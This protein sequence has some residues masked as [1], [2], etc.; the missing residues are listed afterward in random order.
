MSRL[1]AN[2]TDLKNLHV[3]AYAAMDRGEL[4][5]AAQRFGQLV[6]ASPDAPHYHYMRGLAHKYLRDW[7]ASLRDNLAAIATAEESTQ[8]EHWNAA[9]AAT[10]LGDWATAR[11]QWRACG[12]GVPDG[13]GAIEGNYGVAV[14][15]LTPWHGGETVWMRRI[16]PAR[17]RLLNVPLPESG[18]RFGD[19][20]LHD[21][22]SVGTRWNG[23]REVPVFNELQR[24]HTSDFATH[25][26]FVHS[27]SAE[28]RNALRDASLPGIGYVEDW[29]DS[30]RHYCLRCSYGA[31]HDHA[32]ADA[33]GDAWNPD[34]NLGIAAQGRAAVEKLLD[35]WAR[36]PGCRI[37]GIEVPTQAIP[38]CEDG[39]VW[40]QG[41]EEEGAE[42][43][44]RDG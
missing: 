19:I 21:G 13:E 42:D 4:A 24:L 15:R 9:I 20:V 32:E 31:P 38:D 25:V 8:A 27:P 23:E 44:V 1:A 6:E 33:D 29:T 36:R 7:P 39:Q 34:R 28:D 41:P 2:E 43:A 5:A 14:V 11:A 18:H 10:A 30:I 12:V 16:D 22:A 40:W 26:V 17:A 37:Q 35:D 3:A